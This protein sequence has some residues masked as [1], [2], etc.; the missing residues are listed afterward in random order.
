[1]NRL[2]NLTLPPQFRMICALWNLQP[3]E[4]VQFFIDQ[5]CMPGM[6][7]ADAS[8][9]AAALL[10]EYA[11]Q[12]GQEPLPY[13]P[14]QLRLLKTMEQQRRAMLHKIAQLDAGA[15]KKAVERFFERWIKLWE[16]GK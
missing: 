10:M 13:T 2:L 3:Q 1:M 7:T 9:W 16:E 4:A 11:L 12:R 14:R 5:A 8:R 15:R 6:H